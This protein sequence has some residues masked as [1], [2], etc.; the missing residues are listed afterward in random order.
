MTPASM[1]SP[2]PTLPVLLKQ[3]NDHKVSGSIPRPV[4]QGALEQ[5][6]GFKALNEVKK[7]QHSIH[8]PPNRHANVAS[9]AKTIRMSHIYLFIVHLRQ[10][11]LL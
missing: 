2:S 3:A 10:T 11:C 4:A 9:K 1:H 8:N 6:G 7:K 5:K